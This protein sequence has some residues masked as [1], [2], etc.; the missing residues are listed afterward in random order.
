MVS[1]K[2]SVNRLQALRHRRFLNSPFQF[3]SFLSNQDG[4]KHSRESLDRKLKVLQEL[5]KKLDIQIILTGRERNV[6]AC[7]VY[8]LPLELLAQI[9]FLALPTHEAPHGPILQH[10]RHVSHRWRETIDG[11][12]LLWRRIH[13]QD[14]ISHL[15][16]ALVKSAG[17]PMDVYWDS[18]DS[19]KVNSEQFFRTI[20]GTVRLWRSA[21]LRLAESS[22]GG[23]VRQVLETKGAP[24]IEELSLVL[25]SQAAAL[26]WMITP[27]NLFGGVPAPQLRAV[28]ISYLPVVLTSQVFAGL[29]FLHL[30]CVPSTPADVLLILQRSPELQSL[31]LD[32]LP[33]ATDQPIEMTY[34]SVHLPKL[35][36]LHIYGTSVQYARCILTSVDAPNCDN[37]HLATHLGSASPHTALPPSELSQFKSAVGRGVWSISINIK[38]PGHYKVACEGTSCVSLEVNSEH[39]LSR[40]IGW[41]NGVVGSDPSVPISLLFEGCDFSHP[42]FQSLLPVLKRIQGVSDIVVARD[43]PNSQHFIATLTAPDI[44]ANGLLGNRWPNVKKV[45][46]NTP[47][48]FLLPSLLNLV[49]SRA[50]VREIRMSTGSPGYTAIQEL[51]FGERLSNLPPVDRATLKQLRSIQAAL[52]NGTVYWYGVPVAKLHARMRPD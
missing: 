33:R 12:P 22:R 26:E 47:A 30:H 16:Q 8:R 40:S 11:T 50:T 31:L 1:L 3:L 6:I 2:R 51:Y 29:Q 7:A 52:V 4:P 39:A 5:R 32:H 17:T 19:T 9:S 49:K 41:L 25:R 37:F 45:R 48:P 21:T 43:C 23:V 36:K 14:G 28:W 10:L 34:T 27:I 15:N 46:I 13:G 18:Q 38:G 35:E 24:L 42:T 20:G 44:D